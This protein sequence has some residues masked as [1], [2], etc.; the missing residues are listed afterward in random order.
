MWTLVDPPVVFLAN[1]GCPLFSDI[2][3]VP[4][5]PGYLS[6]SS[7][8]A[9]HLKL[10][11]DTFPIARLRSA[12]SMGLRAVG[13]VLRLHG[14]KGRAT[15]ARC[16]EAMNT[17]SFGRSF[18]PYSN[19]DSARLQRHRSI[20]LGSAFHP[21]TPPYAQIYLQYNTSPLHLPWIPENCT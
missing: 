6:I 2:L 10:L 18:S 12:E 14:L 4:V 7:S 11:S 16:D 21:R 19:P 17:T 20:W 13:L 3:L 15:Q 1:R 8:R 5:I 9:L